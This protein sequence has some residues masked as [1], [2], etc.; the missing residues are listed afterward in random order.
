MHLVGS[1]LTVPSWVSVG[2]ALLLL[3]LPVVLSSMLTFILG[4]LPGTSAML[5]TIDHTL[6]DLVPE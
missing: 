6:G 5:G 3:G 4:T 2:L 1:E